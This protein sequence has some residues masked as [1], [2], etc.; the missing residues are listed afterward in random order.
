MVTFPIQYFLVALCS[1]KVKRCMM[2]HVVNK[3]TGGDL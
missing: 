1:V 3:S 2:N